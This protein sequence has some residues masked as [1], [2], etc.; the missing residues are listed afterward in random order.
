MPGLHK[1]GEKGGAP[2][3]LPPQSPRGRPPGQYFGA[4]FCCMHS[5]YYLCTHIKK[6]YP[7]VP[8]GEEKQ[9]NIGKWNHSSMNA[10]WQW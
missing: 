3:A 4:F 7:F 2:S 8:T 1:P 9:K 6:C 10:A 5:L